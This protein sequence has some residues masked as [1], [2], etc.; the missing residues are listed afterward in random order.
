MAVDGRIDL[1]PL[2]RR[3]EKVVTYAYTEIESAGARDVLFKMGSDDGIACWLNGERIHLKNASRNLKVDEDSVKAHLTAGK[4][5]VLLKI[6]QRDNDWAF[7]FRVTDPDGKPL[8]SAA[9]AGK[10]S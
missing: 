1:L 10:T 3:S 9:L 4:N 2:F 7:L 5:K 6:S 8:A